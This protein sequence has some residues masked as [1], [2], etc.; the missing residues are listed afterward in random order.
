LR[1]FF[2]ILNPSK[3]HMEIH[4]KQAINLDFITHYE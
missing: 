2:E 3:I 4:K 1:V